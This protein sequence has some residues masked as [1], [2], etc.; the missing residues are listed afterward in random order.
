MATRFCEH[1]IASLAPCPVPTL[2]VKVL[3]VSGPNLV[4]TH[5]T[6]SQRAQGLLPANLSSSRAP[7]MNYL[8]VATST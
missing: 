1:F 7:G 2:K 6:A 4:H 5:N 8:S 3:D